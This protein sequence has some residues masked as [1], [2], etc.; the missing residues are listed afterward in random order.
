MRAAESSGTGVR[1]REVRIATSRC[2][3]ALLLLMVLPAVAP[4]Q[5]GAPSE[6]RQVDRYKIRVSVDMVVLHA[7]LRNRKG[8][9]VAGLGKGDFQVYEDRVL[10]EIKYFTHE[11][12]P[13]TVGQPDPKKICTSHVERQNLTMRMQI[14]RFTILT[15]GFGR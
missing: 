8:T 7:T 14:R 9:P 12:I 10:Q 6:R 4:P 2:L 13:V 5:E 3:V 1:A 15:N 11:D